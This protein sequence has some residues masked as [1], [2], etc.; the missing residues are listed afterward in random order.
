MDRV[1]EPELMTDDEQA[2]AYAAADFEAPNAAFVEHVRAR[3]DG[4]PAAARVVDLGCGPADIAIRLARLF[5]DFHIDAVDGS[6]AMVR[7]AGQAVARA[8]VASRVRLLQVRI[9]SPQLPPAGYDLVLS[10]SLLHHLP[11]PMAL[12]RE[13]ARI[14]R[15]GARVLVVDLARPASVAAARDLV[16]TYSGAEPEVLKRDFLASLLAAFT[17]PEVSLQLAAAG[18]GDLGTEMV[19]DRHLLVTGRLPRI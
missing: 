16:E 15:P 9:P 4:V 18:L 13:V 8:G 19:S 17:P 6:P 3:V 5:S 2:R 14:G 1:P 10:N 11:D 12:W 7:L